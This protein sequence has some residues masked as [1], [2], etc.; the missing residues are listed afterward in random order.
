SG[1]ARRFTTARR[2]PS[3]HSMKAETDARDAAPRAA[4][5]DRRQ[6]E[7]RRNADA[8]L[9]RIA[10]YLERPEAWPVFPPTR[11]GE[12]RAALPAAPPDAPEPM[13]RILADFDRLLLPNTTH[14][15]PPGFF[16]YFPV[17]SSEPGIIAEMRAATLNVN[18]MVWRT[19]PAATEL[20]QHV[21]GWL[22]QLL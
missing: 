6:D 11:P 4:P 13:D 21:L 10:A 18:A 1:K 20:E 5:A 14:W 16:A 22:R 15:N 8:A 17:S 9:E 3:F 19:G 2:F 7:F 12:V